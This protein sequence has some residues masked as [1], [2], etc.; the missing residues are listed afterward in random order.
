MSQNGYLFRAGALLVSWAVL[1]AC[2][3]P[4][5]LD[6]AEARAPL[7]YG[8]DDRRDLYA[9]E[10]V[11]VRNLALSGT[12]A[13]MP[14]RSFKST[15]TG[16]LVFDTETLSDVFDLC[17]S[18]PFLW[19]PSLANCSGVLVDEDLILTAAHCVTFLP[20][21]DQRWVFGY[22]ILTEGARPELD[23]RTLYECRSVPAH[24][25][26]TTRDGRRRDF[27]V[28][29]LDRPVSLEQRLAT[30]ATGA[31]PI[32]ER[33][34]VIGYPSG[35]PVKVDSGAT[36]LDAR[37]AEAD[38]LRLAS[39]T[40]I[41]SSGSGVFNGQNELLAIV[42]RGGEDYEYRPEAHCYVSRRIV[43]GQE[44]ENGEHASYVS[45]AIASLCESGWASERL[46][47]RSSAC[48]DAQCSVDEHN[49]S[50]PNDCPAIERSRPVVARG[51][52]GCAMAQ[53]GPPS[54]SW[55]LFACAALARKRKRRAR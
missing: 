54:G 6:V 24:D 22:A 10:D 42:V 30:L 51:G 28:V 36:I 35:L 44:L 18:E 14:P 3:A 9:V 43:E 25:Y 40:F 47:H 13:L 5:A 37:D 1:S 53:S 23:E 45:S 33:A 29:Q 20:C 38:Y 49:G 16:S 39:D 50:C 7:I 12:A 48:G 8:S 15:A 31:M 34:T 26:V 11:E 17:D 32:G 4:S 41:G 52:G 19:Q 21:E 2:S 46:C 55:A 27:A